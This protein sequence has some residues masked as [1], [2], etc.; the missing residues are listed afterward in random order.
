MIEILGKAE[1]KT[2]K[3]AAWAITNAASG[4]SS[5]QI[6]YLVDLGCIQPLCDLLT[7]LDAKIVQVAL[8]GLE[9]ILRVGLQD[10]KQT[11][12]GTNIY[13]VYIEECYGNTC[14]YFLLVSTL[15]ILMYFMVVHVAT[16]FFSVYIE[17]FYGSTCDYLF[18]LC[19]H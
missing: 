19:L 8:N 1:F 3:E 6:R 2:R 4:G 15:F 17:E 16:C 9:H 11:S 5:E 13:S 14:G 7:V 12:G 18:L 10:C